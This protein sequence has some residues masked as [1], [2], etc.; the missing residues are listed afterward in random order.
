MKVLHSVVIGQKID[1]QASRREANRARGRRNRAQGEAGQSAIELRLL[2][3]GV[4]M[5]EA[6]HTPWRI[7]RVGG[8]IVGATPMKKVSGDFTGLLL[9]G[10]SVRC[11]AKTVEHLVFSEFA[12]HQV[13]ALDQHHQ[14]GGISLIGWSIPGGDAYV[15]R[16]PVPGF[17]PRTSLSI[18]TAR[19]F[20][21][22]RNK[23]V[24]P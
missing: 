22:T 4:Q 15:L 7:K 19:R 21:L 23:L 24:Q 1:A 6:V 18:E 5:V 3:I 13:K 11:E 17:V 8:R 2:E 12:D 9:G 16:W 20:N 10:R 14:L